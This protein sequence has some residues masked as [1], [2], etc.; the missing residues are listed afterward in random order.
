MVPLFPGFC[1][2]P[3]GHDPSGLGHGRLW[4][5]PTLAK[6]TSTCVC[7]CLC[8]FVCVLVFTVSM[9]GFQGF[10]LV[11]LGPP[12]PGPPFP[13][14]PFPALR[15]SCERPHQT[16]RG[17][18]TTARELQ[19]CTF[20]GP[21]ASNTTKFNVKTPREGR[22]RTNFA[23]E[24]GKKKGEILG[25]H[26]SGPHPSNPLPH[27]LETHKKKPKQLTPKNQNLYIQP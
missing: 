19:T 24:E 16:G 26:P 11:M 5:K 8:V 7:V 9:W 4:P 27:Q 20:Q 23:V 6:P 18:H 25:P 2:D 14:P 1:L 17:S 22:K 15:L 13:G 12:F 21:G 10:G 3:S